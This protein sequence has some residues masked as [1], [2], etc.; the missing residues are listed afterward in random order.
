M[1]RYADKPTNK[2]ALQQSNAK[3]QIEEQA[4]SLNANHGGT[5]R[6]V[7]SAL[8]T[9]EQSRK[10]AI[11]TLSDRLVAI[12]DR[13]LFV[14]DLLSETQRKL[15]EKETGTADGEGAVSALTTLA[16]VYQ[17]VSDWEPVAMLPV[18]P[19]VPM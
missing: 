13:D 2:L 17:V 18:S 11:G 4:E 1:P 19:S 5:L 14:R 10:E 7:I 16:A 8:E 6:D 9:A 12:Q 3:H 15:D